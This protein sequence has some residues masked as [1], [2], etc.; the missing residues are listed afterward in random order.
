MN[1]IAGIL[2]RDKIIPSLFQV[3]SSDFDGKYVTDNS[4]PVKNIKT[5]ST[6]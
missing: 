3:L 4:K 1:C 5:N 2:A 6:R